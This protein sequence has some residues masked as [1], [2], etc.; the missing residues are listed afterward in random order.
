ML[1]TSDR[2]HGKP[3]TD[4]F[5]DPICA[6]EVRANPTDVLDQVTDRLALRHAA[7]VKHFPVDDPHLYVDFLAHLGTPLDNY[8]ARSDS[9][10]YALHPQINVVRCQPGGSR[11]QEQGGPLTAHSGRAFAKH[12]PA[13]TAMLMTK[14]GWPGAPGQAGESIAVR[15]SDAVARH[16]QLFPD[17]ASDDLELLTGT[18]ITITAQHVDS[19]LS[20]LPLL[21]PLPDATGDD[22][23]GARF[24]LVIRDQL[25]GMGLGE[26]LTKGYLAALERFAQ[27]ANDPAT[28][29]VHQLQV[30]QML[31]V[32]NNRFGHGRLTMPT[33]G[34]EGEVTNPREL[35]SAVIE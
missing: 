12:R 19:E 9:P 23:L 31:I 33:T 11:V 20:T 29:Y 32:D 8:G 27:A 30:G 24:S 13:Y 17:T 10:A 21:Y 1:D 18:P 6:R 16:R 26:E 2:T 14:D 15:W 28:R 25:P 35:W 7:L 34:P 5:G 4:L 3:G 22:D